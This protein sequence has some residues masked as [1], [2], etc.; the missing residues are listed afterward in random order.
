MSLPSTEKKLC[1]ACGKPVKGRADKKFC[2]DSCRN[3]YNN[4]QNSSETNYMRRVIN[5]IKKNRRILENILASSDKDTAKCK[6][7]A[8]TTAGFE[9]TYHTSTYTNKQGAVYIFCFEYGYLPLE[10][11]WYFIVKRKEEHKS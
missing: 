9:F 2:D 10:G 6:R 3:N 11:D 5:A 7:E 4:A 8:L 1:L